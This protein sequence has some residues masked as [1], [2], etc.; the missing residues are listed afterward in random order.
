MDHLRC[1]TPE[2][3]EKEIWAHILGYNLIRKVSCQAAQQAGIHPRA[4]S[5]SA[6]RQTLEAAW[7]QLSRA[8]AA[9][10]VR[11]GQHLLAEVANERV[12]N[13][14]DRCEPRALKRRPKEYDRLNKPRAEARANL[15]RG[16]RAND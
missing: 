3:V 2:M 16:R 12:G 8:A 10:R 5:F 15:L 4:V 13:R 9:E 7:S 11:W 1:R 14:P 6:T